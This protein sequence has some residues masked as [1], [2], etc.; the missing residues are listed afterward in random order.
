[1]AVV[2]DGD[3]L[4]LGGVFVT[5]ANA[6]AVPADDTARVPADPFQVSRPADFVDALNCVFGEQTYG[7]A[8]HAKGIV[9]R[10][11]FTPSADAPALSMAPHF[12]HDVP[13]TV[14]FS[15]FAGVPTVS[16]TAAL[17]NPRG[18]AIKF[19]LPDGTETDLIGHSFNGF[20][21][22]TADEFRQLLLAIAASGPDAAHPTA[23]EEFFA[24]HPAA[25]TFLTTQKGPPVS[26]ATLAYFGVNSFKFINALGHEA[27]GRYQIVPD[28][29]EH[30]LDADAVGHAG[31]SYL[32]Q[33][34]T[35]RVAKAPILFRLRVQLATEGD[36][37][38]DPSVTWSD[39]N[40]TVDLGLLSIEAPVGDS[41]AAERELMFL[42]TALPAGIEPADPMLTARTECYPISY[43][44]RHGCP[45]ARV[46]LF[47]SPTLHP[48]LD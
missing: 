40:P 45:A 31:E 18:M 29:G 27:F 41:D 5:V 32:M 3:A 30:L 12:Q 1:M 17:A 46:G 4:L 16:D 21:A 2:H 10:G 28:A 35:G 43:A 22:A 44:R 13:V 34:I 39:L 20:P 6:K 7:R 37:V 48:R 24:T 26:F 19:K 33:E 23:L 9:L 42:P 47:P 15:D 8:V 11:S 25:K 36:K 14:R 38:D